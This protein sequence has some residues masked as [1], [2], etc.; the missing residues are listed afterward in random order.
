[1]RRVCADLLTMRWTSGAGQPREEYVT[2]EDISTTGACVQLEEAVQPGTEVHLE[3]PDASFEGVVRHCMPRDGLYF[4][5]IE[6]AQG[7]RWS[8]GKFKPA[9]LL[10]LWSKQG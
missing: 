8:P 6:F 2:L 10:E 3:H 4:A 9:H 5:G 7:A 1:L